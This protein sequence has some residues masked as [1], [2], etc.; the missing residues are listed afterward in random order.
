VHPKTYAPLWKRLMASTYDLLPLIA[1]LMVA[2]ALMLQL[3][4]AEGVPKSGVERI[5]L[6][7]I[8][9]IPRTGLVHYLYQAL[10]LLLVALY[11]IWSWHRGG[12]TIGMRA[13]R[14]RV[15][16]EAGAKPAFKTASLRFALSLVSIGA[17]G[18]GLIWSLIDPKRRMWH[19]R[20]TG[21]EVIVVPKP[22]KM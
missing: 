11:Y 8:E 1:L 3:T 9:G 16:T 10:I 13:W 20:W 18:L 19:D 21:T 6:N 5:P 2:T 17:L 12:Q 14:L 7:A 15:Q 4:G 22:E